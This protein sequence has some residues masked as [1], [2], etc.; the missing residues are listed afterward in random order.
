MSMDYRK[1]SV[2]DLLPHAG[3][4]VLLDEIVDYNEDS[5]T[6]NVIVTEDSI[7][8]ED[9]LKGVHA[10]VGLEW[11]A[12]AI[13]AVAGIHA[14]QNKQPIRVG[15]LL[16]TRCYKPREIIFPTGHA[17]IIA[18]NK[19]YHEENGLS[20]FECSIHEN[21]NLIVEANL[22]VFAPENVDEFMKQDN[23]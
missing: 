5:V 14:L 20:V 13:A 16:G 7:F 4:M 9:E 22:N 19:L 3:D 1:V 15:F 11:M 17:Y 10:S 8:Y 2:T 21:G 12:Q 6:A 23:E 18:V